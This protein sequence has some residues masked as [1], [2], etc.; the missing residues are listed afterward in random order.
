MESLWYLFSFLLFAWLDSASNCEKEYSYLVSSKDNLWYPK[1]DG[2]REI[3]YSTEACEE[4]N[5]RKIG[6]AF[7]PSFM[8]W[9]GLFVCL[10]NLMPSWSKKSG[11]PIIRKF[12]SHMRLALIVMP[13]LMPRSSR[14][15]STLA[16]PGN[17]GHRS[18]SYAGSI[19]T[20]HDSSKLI[21]LMRVTKQARIWSDR[22]PYDN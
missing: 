13:P 15:S 7:P 9:Q 11:Y 12:S 1:V 8:G 14:L 5:Q 10:F 18:T 22:S 4:E 16:N 2:V 21:P 19:L 20:P 3:Y 6:K 17:R